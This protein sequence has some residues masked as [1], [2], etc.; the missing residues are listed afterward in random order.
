MVFWI[1]PTHVSIFWS[2]VSWIHLWTFIFVLSRH[3][4]PLLLLHVL[5]VVVLLLRGIVKLLL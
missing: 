4:P 2:L 5:V 3:V 1:F